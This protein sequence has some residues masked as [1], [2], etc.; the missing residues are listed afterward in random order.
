MVVHLV[1]RQ[2]LLCLWECGYALLQ[3]LRVQFLHMP[4]THE[5]RL[6][7]MTVHCEAVVP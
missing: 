3:M 7:H 4:V 1:N 6:V 2:E 5:T